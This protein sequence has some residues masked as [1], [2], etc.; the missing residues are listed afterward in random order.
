MS[1]W[2]TTDMNI[3]ERI[4]SNKG[5]IAIVSIIAGL[6][7]LL[8]GI[9]VNKEEVAPIVDTGVDRLVSVAR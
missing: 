3:K 2:Y 1:G 4:K 7:W 8:F 5:K 9:D 6:G